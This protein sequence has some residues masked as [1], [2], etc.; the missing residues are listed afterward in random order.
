MLQ[1]FFE[2]GCNSTLFDGLEI[3]EE[4]KLKIS[5]ELNMTYSQ[6]CTEGNANEFLDTLLHSTDNELDKNI[7]YHGMSLC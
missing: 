2:Y 6:F 1:Y 7:L 5:V 3:A 4:Q